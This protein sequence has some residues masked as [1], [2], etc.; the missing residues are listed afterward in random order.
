MLARLDA[1][2]Y[3]FETAWEDARGPWAAQTA[4]LV[5]HLPGLTLPLSAWTA[6]SDDNAFLNHLLMLFW[7]W[8]TFMNRILDRAALEADLRSLDPP[9]AAGSPPPPRG[10]CFC[11]PFLVNAL[12]ALSCVRGGPLPSRSPRARE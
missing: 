7:T 8:D 1:A 12:L 5:A 10:L 9:A 3:A 2:G 11:S 6:V 4:G